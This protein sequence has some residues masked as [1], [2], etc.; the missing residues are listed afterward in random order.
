[1]P[2]N[3][4][5]KKIMAGMEADHHRDEVKAAPPPVPRGI[6]GE[7]TWES[8]SQTVQIA[9]ERSCQMLT[10]RRTKY[11]EHD[12]IIGNAIEKGIHEW[13][14]CAPNSNANNFVGVSTAACD[15]RIYPAGTA[16]WAMYLHDGELCSGTAAKPTASLGYT[17]QDG[18]R[19][20]LDDGLMNMRAGNGARNPEWQ[21]KALKPIPTNT[22]VVVILDMEERT[23]S[24]AIGSEAPKLAFSNLP[25]VVHPYVC[26]GD[27]EDRSAMEIYGGQ[28]KLK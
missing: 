28:H 7:I 16:A 24:F 5:L 2:T 11:A 8:F 3:A 22:P 27:L 13:T 26:S 10:F 20:F 9:S 23:L 21:K 25:A 15:K 4:D 19:G 17:R 18:T 6:V 14:V 12:A 1:M